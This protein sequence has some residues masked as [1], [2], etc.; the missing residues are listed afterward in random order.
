MKRIKFD[1]DAMA[2]LREAV[3]AKIRTEVQPEISAQGRDVLRQVNADM[4]GQPADE[5][6]KT[7]RSRMSGPDMGPADEK[8]RLYAEAI[9][10]GTLTE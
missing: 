1:D 8:L 6:L 2:H 10:E 9:S 5:V 3:T 7:L 4:A